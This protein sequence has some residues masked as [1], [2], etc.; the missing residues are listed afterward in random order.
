TE[1]G[2]GKKHT[3]APAAKAELKMWSAYADA[4][5]ISKGAEKTAN[6]FRPFERLWDWARGTEARGGY[7]S[8]LP[9]DEAQAR[10]KLA[11]SYSTGH[12]YAKYPMRSSERLSRE[13]APYVKKFAPENR[14]RVRQ[15]L[16]NTD[17][18][19]LEQAVA[20]A[21]AYL[22][23]HPG[24][25]DLTYELWKRTSDHQ[26][27][28]LGIKHAVKTVQAYPEYRD[29]IDRAVGIF[30]TY[31]PELNKIR[32][33]RTKNNNHLLEWTNALYRV[34]GGQYRRQANAHKSTADKSTTQA[35]KHDEDFRRE[36]EYARQKTEQAK[37]FDTKAEK[38]KTDKKDKDAEQFANEAKKLRADVVKHQAAAKKH[39]A[40][41][42]DLRAKKARANADYGKDST[43]TPSMEFLLAMVQFSSADEDYEEAYAYLDEAVELY[44]LTITPEQTTRLQ[45]ARIDVLIA[46]GNLDTAFPLIKQVM[47]E[48]VRRS[49][50]WI[51]EIQLGKIDYFRE[52]YAEC[53]KRFQKVAKLYDPATSPRAL[54]WIGK[55]KLALDTPDEAI[56]AFKELW[57]QYGNDDLI[58]Q[59]IYL[60]GQTFRKRGEFVDAIRLFESVGVM[61]ASAKDKIIPGEDVLL[62]I[63]DPDYAVGTGKD[64]MGIDVETTAGDAEKVR[65]DMNP[66]NRALFVGSIKSKLGKPRRNSGLLELRGNDVITIRYFDEFGKMTIEYGQGSEIDAAAATVGGVQGTDLAQDIGSELFGT[67]NI[68]YLARASDKGLESAM[69]GY[70]D[71]GG[72]KSFTVGVRFL[73]PRLVT[74]V[75]I[76]ITG[77]SHPKNFEVQV[78]SKDG[79][80][81]NPE[82]WLVRGKVEGLEGKGWQDIDFPLSATKAVRI[83]VPN[84]PD[85]LSWKYINEIQVIEGSTSEGWGKDDIKITVEGS[86]E[87]TFKLYVVDT[88]QI[89]ISSVRFEDE[90]KKEGPGRW[91]PIEP[92][93]EEEEV[94]PLEVTVAR[95]RPG[96]ITPG[97]TAFV[98]PK[99][100][101]FD[102]TDER[103]TIRVVAYAM[104]KALTGERVSMDS[105]EIEL[106]EIGE[107]VGEF[108]GLIQ[109]RPS[110]PTVSAS[111]TAVGFSA[112]FAINNDAS[113]QSAWQA[114]IDGLPGK[115]IE[116]DLKDVYE[117]AEIQWSRGTGAQ[118]R[119]INDGSITIG[120][121]DDFREITFEGNQKANGNVVKVDPPALG[122]YVRLAAN[123]YDGD[124]PAIAQIIIKDAKG[125]QLVPTDITPEVMRTNDVLELNVGDSIQ[126]EYLDE[127]NMDPGKPTKRASN[128]LSVQYYNAGVTMAIAK[129]DKFGHVINAR[130][131]ALINAG[132]L[133]QIMIH[134]VD[135]DKNDEEQSVKLFIG[136]ESGDSMEVTAKETKGDSGTFAVD[137]KSSGKP[138]AMEDPRRLYVREGDALWATYMDNKNMTPGHKTIRSAMIFEAT[139]TSGRIEPS[140]AYIAPVPNFMGV[141]AL[142]TGAAK[143]PTAGIKVVDSD[144]AVSPYA[145]I[146]MYMG[147]N[148]RGDRRIVFAGASNLTGGMTASVSMTKIEDA[149]PYWAQQELA[150][151]QLIFTPEEVEDWVKTLEE[152]GDQKRRELA[153]GSALPVLGD[154]VIFSQY[155]DKIGSTSAISHSRV[156]SRALFETAAK[157]TATK[158]FPAADSKEFL[159]FSPVIELE[160]PETVIE[161]EQTIREETYTRLM[162]NRYAMYEKMLAFQTRQKDDLLARLEEA[163]AQEQKALEG[164][165]GEKPPAPA[166]AQ[167][168]EAPPG[169]EAAGDA[170][171]QEKPDAA[172]PQA[173]EDNKPAADADAPAKEGTTE[174]VD[175]PEE[176]L[177]DGLMGIEGS[178][179]VGTKGELAVLTA[180]EILEERIRKAEEDIE[181]TQALVD[182][183]E[184]F[185]LPEDRLAPPGP[186]K[187]EPIEREVGERYLP[188]LMAPAPGYPFRIWITD[189][190]LT[191]QGK[192]KVV[193]RSYSHG[194]LGRLELEAVFTEVEDMETKEK[195]Q[196]L[197]AIVP[198]A[199]A[200]PGGK[201]E[202]GGVL[203][204]VFGGYLRITYEDDL[205]QVPE[206]KPIPR[207]NGLHH[208]E[209]GWQPRIQAVAQP[210][211]LCSG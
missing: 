22:A 130:K 35:G 155:I 113:P 102:I 61:R 99:D 65:V 47:A 149:E 33:N 103:E 49:A 185:E 170:A 161:E 108:R 188:Y 82:S 18:P 41:A 81:K 40:D 76:Y 87:K 34:D 141:M 148:N 72:H 139:P 63:V 118:D 11:D 100:K 196:V 64:Y 83:F 73:R 123:F 192:C 127:E 111:D 146:P 68:N 16:S 210:S 132:D 122:R 107:N 124:A 23:K 158:P 160:D 197:Q 88:G 137:V 126:M 121:A 199:L 31:S 27:W 187:P 144:A 198:T 93:E 54:F 55:T 7:R 17:L 52:R 51:G 129:L 39:E 154:D 163:K 145:R 98:R 1:P 26:R 168:K 97:N 29:V 191:Q 140:K 21:E 167:P 172:A 50:Y 36:T 177:P 173:N 71:D 48:N 134:D 116:V 190:D 207:R 101:D 12:P 157:G 119:V 143:A 112:D 24:D 151:D 203:P 159:A 85:N 135:E 15:L 152:A 80:E 96:Q 136:S 62:K 181:A 150:F 179:A 131:T 3:L 92:D 184:E 94:N 53:L 19:R 10:I 59:A 38:A 58:I 95:R 117:I 171:G 28:P 44:K 120:S 202:A 5:K 195:H 208:A 133:F 69:G 209:S 169:P 153:T 43:K 78:L 114:Q 86:K 115:W 104:G 166:D 175:T 4:E 128:A 14:S 183:Y 6:A 193:V 57:E 200:P 13:L 110:A 162:G 45:I 125:T 174:T 90:E 42:K 182:R 211:G 75:R 164:K 204:L 156:I 66:I 2:G 138:E 205:Q 46:E 79:D 147:A 9:L 201:L 60:I 206:N 178:S 20:A 70:T 91:K 105:C 194:C 30:T 77:T 37:S 89:E 142:G 106:E 189:R 74:K 8:L 165:E 32:Y 109:T 25:W 84:H 56:E 186:E 176:D 180:V 67:G